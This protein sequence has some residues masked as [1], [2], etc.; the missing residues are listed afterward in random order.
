MAALAD[1]V[2]FQLQN[3]KALSE[4]LSS[5]KTAITSRQSN[6]I[7]RIAKE[8]VVLVEQLRSTDQRIATHTNISEYPE[9]AQLVATIKSI[10]HDCQQAN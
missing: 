2:N 7:E 10:V 8:K 5:E 4:L 6:D 3:A 9:L 1:L